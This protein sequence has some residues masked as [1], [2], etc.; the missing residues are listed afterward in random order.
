MKITRVGALTLTMAFL[1]SGCN[2]AGDEVPGELTAVIVD[3]ESA[4]F[5]EVESFTVKDGDQ[6]YEI[7]TA[8]DGDYGFPLGHLHEHLQAAEP[9]RMDLEER[10]GRLFALT[11]DDA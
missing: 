11:I 1:M 9:V 4:G 10:D 5:G 2:S 6:T 8:E 3:I 7:F